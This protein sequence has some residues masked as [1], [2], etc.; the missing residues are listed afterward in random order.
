MLMAMD[1]FK[2]AFGNRIPPLVAGRNLGLLAADHI[3]PLKKAFMRQALGLGDEL[4][5]LA[6]PHGAD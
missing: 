3:G 6:R 4:P 2:R 1:A 5:S